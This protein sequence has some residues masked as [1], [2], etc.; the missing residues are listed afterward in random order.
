MKITYK[1]ISLI[2][3][4]GCLGGLAKGLAAWLCGAS[5]INALLGSQ[6]APP[7][8]T[9]WV[10]A[11]VV[12]GGIW[13]LL[14]LLPIRGWSVYSLGILYS[15]PQAL[16]SLLVM[17]PKMNRGLLGLQLG[18]STPVLVVLFGFVWG[19]ATAFWWQHARESAG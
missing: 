3:A 17:F 12:W 14:F 9:Q 5:G 10:Y 4:A 19:L 11:H 13:A 7:L 18:Y 2:F 6:F 1:T 16:I 15:L 8:T